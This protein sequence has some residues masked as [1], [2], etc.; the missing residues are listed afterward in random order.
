[1]GFRVQDLGLGV[2]QLMGFRAEDLKQ[3]REAWSIIILKPLHNQVR[4]RGIH[5]SSYL[6]PKLALNPPKITC[7]GFTLK[8]LAFRPGSLQEKLEAGCWLKELLVPETGRGTLRGVGR[9]G[10]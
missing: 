7:L 3:Q 8:I 10:G 2:V 9:G 5:H 4:Y 1:M 6:Y